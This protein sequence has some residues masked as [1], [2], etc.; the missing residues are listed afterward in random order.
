VGRINGDYGRIGQPAVHY[1]H[2]SYDRP[3][4][5]ALLRAADVMVITPLRDGMNLVAKEYV[6]ARTDLG[7]ALVLSEFAGAADEL[8]AAFLVNPHDID[9]LKR[10]LLDAMNAHD[11]ELASRMSALREQVVGHDV[12]RWAQEFVSAL[13]DE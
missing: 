8:T 7:G 11:D 4:L 9:G 1:L 2:S 13:R 10:T 5:V 6:A 12:N 3:E